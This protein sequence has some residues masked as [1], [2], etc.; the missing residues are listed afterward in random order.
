[1]NPEPLEIQDYIL[2]HLIALMYDYLEPEAYKHGRNF[3]MY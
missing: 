2:H 3:S 1:M